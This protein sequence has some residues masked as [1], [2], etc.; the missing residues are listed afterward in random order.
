MPAEFAADEQAKVYI[1][2]KL[3]AHEV[4]RA[5]QTQFHGTGDMMLTRVRRPD[6]IAP[7][8]CAFENDGCD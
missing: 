5:M 1:C 4:E 2:D 8:G 6:P 7:E 3:N